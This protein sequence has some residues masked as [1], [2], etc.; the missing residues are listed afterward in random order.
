MEILVA[1]RNIATELEEADVEF[2]VEESGVVDFSLSFFFFC[3]LRFSIGWEG[4]A[5][6]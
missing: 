5:E 4:G 3:F 1:L 6:A 2:A